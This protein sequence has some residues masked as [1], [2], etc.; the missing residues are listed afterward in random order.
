MCFSKAVTAADQVS[1]LVKE[2]AAHIKG[3]VWE[4][5]LRLHVQVLYLNNVKEN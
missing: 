2:E 3:V 4:I 1:T 5:Q